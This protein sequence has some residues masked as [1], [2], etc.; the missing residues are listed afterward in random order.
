M[1]TMANTRLRILD[2]TG[3]EEANRVDQAEADRQ[4]LSHELMENRNQ[5]RDALNIKAPLIQAIDAWHGTGIENP[6]WREIDEAHPE[7]AVDLE[8]VSIWLRGF[9]LIYII[10]A[11][12]I[13]ALIILPVTA[14][15]VISS[16]I[17][18]VI[19]KVAGKRNGTNY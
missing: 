2:N 17:L 14:I 3:V 8:P 6:D 18:W 4:A 16:P 7:P 12:A 9:V 19:D 13:G 5:M 11:L 15:A 1:M 10:I